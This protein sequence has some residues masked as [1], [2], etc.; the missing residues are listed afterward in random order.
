MLRNLVL[1]WTK[2]GPNLEKRTV[3]Y[4]T[5]INLHKVLS[6]SNLASITNSGI[7]EKDLLEDARENHLLL[8]VK[9]TH[10]LFRT[11]L[12]KGVVKSWKH[13]IHNT[14]QLCIFLSISKH[15]AYTKTKN[16]SSSRCYVL[17]STRRRSRALGASVKRK[18]AGGLYGCRRI[19]LC[20]CQLECTRTPQNSQAPG[21]CRHSLLCA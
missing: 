15:L 12:W 13:A 3:K 5:R 2:R 17:R 11:T 4:T 9:N 20:C 21:V 14:C 6:I 7:H 10:L 16:L 19:P 8:K 1:Q 18:S